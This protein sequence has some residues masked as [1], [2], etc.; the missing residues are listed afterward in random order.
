MW[1]PALAKKRKNWY[2][3]GIDIIGRSA[4]RRGRKA[5]GA[6][7]QRFEPAGC[8]PPA[9]WTGASQGCFAL[10]LPKQRRTGCEKGLDNVRFCGAPV[11]AQV[12]EFWKAAR[13]CVE[14]GLMKDYG[15]SFK[16]GKYTF[17]WQVIKA[18]NRVQKMN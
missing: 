8:K 7:L 12:T 11:F 1:G 4:V 2:I 5:T 6:S 9:H 10:E 13:W 3:L 14:Q 15:E 17:R 18:W 16:P